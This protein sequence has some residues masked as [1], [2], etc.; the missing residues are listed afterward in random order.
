[1]KI[2]ALVLVRM[3]SSR[4][5]GKP[6]KQVMGTSILDFLLLRLG[7]CRRLDQI[8]VTIPNGQKDDVLQKHCEKRNISFFRGDEE[9]VLGRIAGAV[10]KFQLD[11]GVT[12]FGDCPLIDPAIVDST[13]DY[14]KSQRG[15][16]D[17]VGNDLK[18]T[19]PPGMEVEV[20]TKES[21]HQ[22]SLIESDPS[23]REHG[24]LHIRQN[25]S[26]FKLHNIECSG[27]FFRPELELELDSQED[28]EVIEKVITHFHPRTDFSLDEIID[29]MDKNPELLAKNGNVPRKWK[30][31]R[32]ED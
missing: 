10:A 14:F 25:P 8:I 30:E 24:T 29:Y 12:I 19:F 7:Q 21:I 15:K 31:Y 2:G 6:L 26:Q 13:I 5:P 4:L 11:A 18:T 9:D 17:F 28:F 20:F 27:K 32:N 23:I 22:A 3:G 16:Y 1:V